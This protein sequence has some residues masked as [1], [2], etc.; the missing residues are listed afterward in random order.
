MLSLSLADR[1]TLAGDADQAI[2][3]A[4]DGTTTGWKPYA[5]RNEPEAVA[6]ITSVALPAAARAWSSTL[7]PLGYKLE[8]TG[9]FCHQ[10]PQV[11]FPKVDGRQGR[12]ELADLLIVVDE[13]VGGAPIDRR[14]VLVQSK[15]A[16]HPTK[17][18]S[19]GDLVQLDLYQN[20]PKFDFL[21]KAAYAAF[22]R[23]FR[24]SRAPGAVSEG[25]DYGAIDLL[26][27]AVG[28][29]AI[30]ATNPLVIG[31]GHSLGQAIAD[32]V[33]GA[34]GRETHPNGSDDWSLTIDELLKVTYGT[35]AGGYPGLPSRGVTTP[36]FMAFGPTWS[37]A[38]FNLG[39]LD[40]AP[41]GEA[42]AGFGDEDGP[43]SLIHIRIGRY[44]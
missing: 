39:G 22:A 31:G 9:V 3:D 10:T 4:L 14:A 5:P 30:D 34:H 37:T 19:G 12:C 35:V 25:R 2:S 38:A 16:G 40:Q 6:A 7:G 11:T 36:T 20:W 32:M 26:P 33:V 8:I 41:P 13:H 21:N 27:A 23:D 18:L 15:I 17:T 1:N 29:E 44:D 28:W 24:S 43:G 42:G